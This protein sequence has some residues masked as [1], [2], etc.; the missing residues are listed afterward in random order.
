VSESDTLELPPE[1]TSPSRARRWIQPIVIDRVRDMEAL[2]LCVS[3]LVANAVLHAGTR[4]VL[5]VDWAD[6]LLR[7]AVRDFAPERLPV[8]RHFDRAAMTGRGLHILD[9]CTVRWGIDRDAKA[10]SVWFEL[11]VRDRHG[12]SS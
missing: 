5:S 2:L 1:R 6:D 9:S 8:K 12:A 10:K 4:C 11:P 7:I 3:E